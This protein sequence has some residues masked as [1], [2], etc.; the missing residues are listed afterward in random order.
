MRS[1]SQQIEKFLSSLASCNYLTLF[2][3]SS[4]RNEESTLEIA[5]PK[6]YS[7]VIADQIFTFKYPQLFDAEFLNKACPYSF[8]LQKFL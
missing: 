3:V 8:L 7:S 2:T 6:Y 1:R 4:S 5:S